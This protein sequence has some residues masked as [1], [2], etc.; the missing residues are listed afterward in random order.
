MDQK[1]QIWLLRRRRI[2]EIIEVGTSGVF[3]SRGYDFL[4]TI[5]LL[6][7]VVVTVLYTFDEIE[8]KH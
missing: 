4:S 2:S 3:V 1:R 5:I 8:M 6:T 7:N